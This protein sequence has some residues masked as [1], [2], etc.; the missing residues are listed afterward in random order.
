MLEYHQSAC[1]L[2][3][4]RHGWLDLG[5]TC[6]TQASP[7]TPVGLIPRAVASVSAGIVYW[8][9]AELPGFQASPT[10]NCPTAEWFSVRAALDAPRKSPI[11]LPRSAIWGNSP[12]AFQA[13]IT[14]L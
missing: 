3:L 12:V 5:S 14:H 13:V 2:P 7:P 10:R 11:R 9:R 8:G 4:V 6:S 1:Y